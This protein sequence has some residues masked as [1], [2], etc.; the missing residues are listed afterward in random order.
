MK[1][2]IVPFTKGNMLCDARSKLSKW[3]DNLLK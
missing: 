3:S 2:D 1:N